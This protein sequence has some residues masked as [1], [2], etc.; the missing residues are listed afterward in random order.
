MSVPLNYN[1]EYILAQIFNVAAKLKAVAHTPVW[2]R[3][4]RF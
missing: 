3:Q 2:S 4:G 1:I